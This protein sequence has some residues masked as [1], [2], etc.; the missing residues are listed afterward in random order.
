MRCW[1]H[2]RASPRPPDPRAAGHRPGGVTGK[3]HATIPPVVAP[4]RRLFI[5]RR[6]VTTGA[7]ATLVAAGAA[8]LA[9]CGSTTLPSGVVAQVGDS[10]I[11]RA[12]LDTYVSQLAASASSQGQSF[13]TPG[14]PSYRQAQQ[15]GVQ[16]LIQLDVVGFEAGKCGRPCAVSDAEI[17][18]QLNSLA[19]QRFG[20]SSVKL[21]AYLKS[22][23]FTVDQARDQVKAGLEQQKIQ[24]QVE[25]SV[26]FTPA[27]AKAYYA[28]HA[29]QYRQPETRTVSHIL[30]T[31][32]ALANT[33]AG[34]ATP[35][36]FAALAKRYSID[37]GS[38]N[39][40]GSIGAIKQSDVVAA[41][42][43]A[44]FALPVGHISKPVHSQY[45][46]HVIYVT[47]ITPPHTVALAAALPGIIQTQLAAART[48]AYQKWVTSTLAYWNARTTYASGFAPASS[49]LGTSTAG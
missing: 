30:V 34:E 23:G 4:S 9:G 43:T 22:L 21:A 35:A 38:K 11:T 28:A 36:N 14:T 18:A 26:T 15:Q 12:Q 42:G 10:Q 31:N 25:R 1:R 45:G 24:K 2:S 41:F 47:K 40:G 33:I 3:G 46:W 20:G 6:R 8:V 49:S 19:Q 39:L 44:A 32:R 37:T 27:E 29:S 48:A 17:T 13:P 7:L 16:Q 5:S